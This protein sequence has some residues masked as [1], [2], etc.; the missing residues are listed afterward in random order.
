ML[1]SNRNA[2]TSRFAGLQRWM[3]G[4]TGRNEHAVKIF[5]ADDDVEGCSS[6]LSYNPNSRLFLSTLSVLPSEIIG[7]TPEGG[8]AQTP[9]AEVF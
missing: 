7:F 9:I 5:A 1:F 6:S 2:G 8:R 3:S 4:A